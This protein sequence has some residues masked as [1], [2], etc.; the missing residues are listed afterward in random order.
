[1]TPRF[2]AVPE[3]S[4]VIGNLTGLPPIRSSLTAGCLLALRSY[5]YSEKGLKGAGV[6]EP[7]R[8]PFWEASPDYERQMPYGLRSKLAFADLRGVR[9]CSQTDPLSDLCQEGL[10]PLHTCFEVLAFLCDSCFLRKSGRSG[11]GSSLLHESHEAREF[12]SRHRPIGVP[13]LGIA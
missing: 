6:W 13:A 12:P 2:G 11:L 1:M 3:E 10:G 9:P 8:S 7:P 5:G 4:R